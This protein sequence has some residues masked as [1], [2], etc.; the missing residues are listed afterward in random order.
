MGGDAQHM[1]ALQRGNTELGRGLVG[2]AGKAPGGRHRAFGQFGEGRWRG[3]AGIFGQSRARHA[4]QCQPG[5]SCG[6]LAKMLEM[7]RWSSLRMHERVVFHCVHRGQQSGQFKALGADC[8][9][10]QAA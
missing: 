4:R 10:E 9:Q 1:L 2:Q 7:A 5:R 3:G 8:A 6:P